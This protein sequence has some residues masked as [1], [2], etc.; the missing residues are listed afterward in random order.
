M[1]QLTP[2]DD[3]AQRDRLQ[4]LLD[5]E[6]DGAPY[7]A[8]LTYVLDTENKGDGMIAQNFRTLKVSNSAPNTTDFMTFKGL[9]TTLKFEIDKFVGGMFPPPV[10]GKPPEGGSHYG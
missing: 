9:M 5:K 7:M 4:R 10:S 6:F 3:K 2:Q 8:V 1:R